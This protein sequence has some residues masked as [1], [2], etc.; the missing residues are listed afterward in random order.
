[1]AGDMEDCDILKTV[2]CIN[3][4][5][6]KHQS[7]FVLVVFQSEVQ[8]HIR[9]EIKV[10]LSD[11]SHIVTKGTE[12]YKL[13]DLKGKVIL[14][15]DHKGDFL[16]NQLEHEENYPFTDFTLNIV[17][18]ERNVDIKALSHVYSFGSLVSKDVDT[19]VALTINTR[20]HLLDNYISEMIKSDEVC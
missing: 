6:E 4:F 7:K 14:C 9:D 20:N 18:N 2:H 3:E 8:Q 1:M 17:I 11:K 5:V 13:W 19:T 16:V 15:F 10:K 12:N